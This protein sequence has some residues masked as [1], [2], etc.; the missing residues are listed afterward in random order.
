[1]LLIISGFIVKGCIAM[2]KKKKRLSYRA[3]SILV[4]LVLI[5]I[6]RYF[7]ISNP[8]MLLIIPVIYFAFVDGYI[9]GGISAVI[10]GAYSLVFFSSPGQLFSYDFINLQKVG[11]IVAALVVIVVLIGQL[12][13]K[14]AAAE[15]EQAALR[16]R[17]E[18]LSRM[19][20][21]IRTPLNGIL[22]MTKLAMEEENPAVIKK[23][24]S[25]VN[26]SGVYLLGLV[27]E[28][29]DLFQ[30]E[31]RKL[32][33]HRRPYSMAAFRVYLEAVIE[34]L[35]YDRDIMLDIDF[36]NCKDRTFYL[37]KLRFN[38]VFTNLLS[39]AVKNS[40]DH[41]RVHVVVE[42]VSKQADSMDLTISVIDHGIG[43]SEA[44]QKL[45]FTPYERENNALTVERKGTGLGLAIVYYLV[46]QAGGTVNVQSKEGTGSTFCVK[47]PAVR[48]APLSLKN[49]TGSSAGV[50]NLAGLHVL[51]CEDNEINADIVIL[52]LRQ[53]GVAVTL[54]KNGADGVAVFKRS[55]VGNFDAILMDV[56]MPRMDG[57]KAARTIRNLAR[58][59]SKTVPIIALSADAFEHDVELS[60]ASGM[61]A[62]VAKPVDMDKLCS[63][64]AQLVSSDVNINN[65]NEMK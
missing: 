35:C 21:D 11:L 41:G 52:N 13:A 7:Q 19:S 48:I 28:I 36:C 64:L 40:Y 62:H 50:V 51:L 43:M 6:A 44:F 47:L 32:T 15:S 22:G 2:D 46:T 8:M 65:K 17:N 23:Y 1:M 3:S 30:L 56:R 55:A 10:V 34:P 53:K 25:K 58:D 38:Q 39:N 27:N 24:L 61:D 31:N 54:A 9:S 37:D 45:L 49:E 14:L 12:K 16:T 4:S 63:L 29:L 26:D 20:H 42:G 5:F 18:F 59:D 33:F 60:L 57:R